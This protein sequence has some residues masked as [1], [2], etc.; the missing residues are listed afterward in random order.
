MGSTKTVLT[1]A[2][3]AMRFAFR[4]EDGAVPGPRRLRGGGEELP[5]GLAPALL[6]EGVAGGE[7]G[8][9]APRRQSPEKSCS[10]GTFFDFFKGNQRKTPPV[11][12][13]V[14]FEGK[15]SCISLEDGWSESISSGGKFS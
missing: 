8:G 2:I 15:R 13:K 6:A 3:C 1:T 9:A 5:R 10:K 12:C 7:G 14:P 4:A 11:C